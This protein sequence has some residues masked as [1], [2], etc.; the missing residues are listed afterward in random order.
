MWVPTTEI[1]RPSTVR[2]T[3]SAARSTRSARSPLMGT[4][5]VLSMGSS[6]RTSTAIPSVPGSARCQRSNAWTL[7]GKGRSPSRYSARL[8]CRPGRAGHPGVAG[9]GLGADAAPAGRACA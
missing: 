6:G 5:L 3:T 8:L 7:S 4:T 1:G 2:S 9:V